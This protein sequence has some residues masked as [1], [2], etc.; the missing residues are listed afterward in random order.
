MNSPKNVIILTGGL[1]GSSVLTSLLGQAG[2]WYGDSTVK[3][4]D[5]DTWENSELVDLNKQMLANI[6]FDEPWTMTF[7]P[8]YIDRVASGL[9]AI[10]DTQARSFFDRC[11]Q[12]NPW[13]WKDPRLWL[14][15]RFWQRFIDFSSTAFLVIRRELLQSWISTTIRK[16][17]QTRDHLRHYNDGVHRTI[18]DFVEQND[19]Q[20][21]DILYE[22]LIVDPESTIRRI[23]AAVNT[24]LSVSDFEKVFRG[25]LYKK[26]H[27]PKSFLRASAIYL[28]NYSDRYR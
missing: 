12:H 28:K 9:S 14:T 16:Q 5:Y 3:K 11:D 20:Y 13:V 7:K 4:T 21:V 27:G 26:Q 10:D 6:G 1:A 8:G 25:D 15:I 18:I 19:A 2:Y 24:E 22:E 23:N 17:I